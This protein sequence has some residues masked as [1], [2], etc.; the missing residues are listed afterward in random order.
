MCVVLK[1]YLPASLLTPFTE[2]R[3]KVLGGVMSNL[4]KEQAQFL[5][6]LASRGTAR[7]QKLA[8]ISTIDKR[9]LKAISKISHNVLM[10]PG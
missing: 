4:L 6:L 5:I 9:Q 8:L 3:E 2:K 7:C 1:R 10:G